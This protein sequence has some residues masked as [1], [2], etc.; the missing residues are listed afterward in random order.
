[1]VEAHVLDRLV[2]KQGSFI[3]SVVL[4]TWGQ[5]ES[6]IAALLADVP[7]REGSWLQ[8]RASFPDILL[9]AVGSGSDE[10]DAWT[11][12]NAL[13]EEV[14]R[15]LG[16]LIYGEGER[17]FEE[18]MGALLLDGE[19]TVATAESCT[20]GL[21]ASQLTSIPGSSAYFLEGVVTYSNAA[22]HRTLGVSSATLDLHGAV[23]EATVREMVTGICRISGAR[24]G[25]AVS[26]IAGPEG[27]S[28]GKPVGT[29][30]LAACVDGDTVHR[31]VCFPGD[32]HRVRQ[33]AART[34]LDMARRLCEN[35]NTPND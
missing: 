33:L 32:R 9:T 13:A 21:I 6:G 23:S 14:R 34:A 1:M 11:R 12:A 25:I 18:S 27:G 4:R 15:R 5:P 28:P 31:C 10:R 26:G 7:E 17:T 20:G 3:A 2:E 8:Y 22:K 19:W 30:H 29:V 16:D 24:L 35:Q